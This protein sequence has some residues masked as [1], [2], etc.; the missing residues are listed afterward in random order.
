MWGG[1]GIREIVDERGKW[2]GECSVR[3]TSGW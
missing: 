1:G 2:E 3:G